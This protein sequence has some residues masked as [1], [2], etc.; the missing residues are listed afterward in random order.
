MTALQDAVRGQVI[1]PGHEDYDQARRVWNGAIDRHPAMVVR[2]AG[3]ADVLASVRYAREHDLLMA[4][5]GGGHNV[6]GSGTCDDGMVIDLS[7]MKGVRVDPVARTAWA[8]PGLVWRELDAETQAFGLAVTGGIVSG[9]G[10]AGFTLGGGIGWLHRPYGFTVD[11]L[12]GADMVTAAGELVR[13]TEQDNP[14][15]LW[16]L[17]GG[18]GNF[19][20][21]TTFEYQQHPV[22][23]ELMAGLVFYHGKDLPQ[24]VAGFRDLML[25]APDELTLFL[26]M[27]RAPAAPFLPTE[28]H[29]QPVV[30]V[31]GCYVGSLEDGARALAPLSGFATPIVNLMQPRQY[32]QFQSMLDG[33]W[34]PGF[35]NYWKAEYLTGIPD[36]ALPILSEHLD[37][38]TSPLSD[39]KFASLG[40]AAGRVPADATA[41]SHRSSPFV[42][43]INARWALPGDDGPHV[44]WTRKLWEA[45]QPYSAGGSYV[46]F[47][48]EEGA[49]RVRAAYG[50][51]T[52]KRLVALK[53][54]Y[55]PDN[56]FRLNQNIAPEG[57]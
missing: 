11:N 5:R 16:G 49:D 44:A 12:T 24:V 2:C 48:G 3:V 27:R 1:L 47:M 56:A 57:R 7:A 4:V 28:V 35:G 18:G 14:E 19:G 9:T 39:F 17:R 30:A 13:V 52:Y 46:N 25:A 20:I 41:F 37:E 26:V 40:G 33:S 50:D 15:L 10:I 42:L 22:G 31:V 51:T 43:N 38:I 6:A 54:S 34:A 36:E 53:N 45:M 8:Q 29:G 23:P 21:V 55:D 32:T